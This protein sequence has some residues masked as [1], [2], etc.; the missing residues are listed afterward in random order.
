MTQRV[1]EILDVERF[2]STGL[3]AIWRFLAFCLALM[4]LGVFLV[5]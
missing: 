4:V 5:T 3:V 1:L 2:L